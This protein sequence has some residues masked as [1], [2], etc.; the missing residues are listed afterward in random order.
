MPLQEKEISVFVPVYVNSDL[1]DSLLEELVRDNYENK[2]IF[3]IIDNPNQDS[4]NLVEKYKNKVF[5]ILNNQRIG[6]VNALNKAVNYSKGDILLFLDSDIKL[7]NNDGSF[8][9][10]IVSEMTETDIL[11]IKKDI[12]RDSF[13][14]KMVNYEYISSNFVSYLYSRFAKKCVG[15]NGAAFAIKKDVFK[16]V[17]GFSK[18]VSE[19]FDLA[20]KVALR[21][22]Y[23]KFYEKIEVK[24]KS[25]GT[26]KDWFAQRKRW[27]IGVGLWLKDH[28]RELLKYVRQYPSLALLSF[29]ILFPTF[30][31]ILLSYFLSNFLGYKLLNFIIIFF[32]TKF[33]LL[34]AFPFIFSIS[35]LLLTS[36]MNFVIS[37]IL[38]L[39]LFFLFAKKLNFHFNILEFTIYYY[40]YQPFAFFVLIIGIIT[41][42]VYKKYK[43]DWKI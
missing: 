30:I 26:W 23:F 43:L 33:P 25:P 41:P 40:F 36:F 15:I 24:T 19:D 14:S 35:L 34:I 10:K 7:N 11:D 17:G 18:V 21:D 29:V 1:L 42:F 38:F 16:E 3:V 5:F 20:I 12:I 39:T 32:A 2:E 28:W 9:S 22:K 37:F 31:P 6:K 27:S 8:L 13:I 4:L